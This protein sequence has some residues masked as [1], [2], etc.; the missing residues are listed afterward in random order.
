MGNKSL[1][2]HRQSPET[3]TQPPPATITH[4]LPDH[5]ES[6]KRDEQEKSSVNLTPRRTKAEGGEG[7]NRQR[8]GENKTYHVAMKQPRR[9][10]HNDN[11][12]MIS[13]SARRLFQITLFAH[14]DGHF[15][16]VIS[17]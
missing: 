3:E 1:T 16:Q 4:P 8:A 14:L 10:A 12:L 11:V 6:P 17:Q 13:S 5:T 9:H 15:I 7:R 2:E